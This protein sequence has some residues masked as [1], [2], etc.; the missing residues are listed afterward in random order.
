M[1]EILHPIQVFDLAESEFGAIFGIYFKETPLIR[2]YVHFCP[3]FYRF[4]PKKFYPMGF[5][6][7]KSSKFYCK[8]TF[9]GIIT[10]TRIFLILTNSYIFNPTAV[11]NVFEY[12]K[13]NHAKSQI[14]F[15]T[16]TIFATVILFSSIAILYQVIIW[17]AYKEARRSIARSA[18]SRKSIYE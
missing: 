10:I 9:Q 4:K 12:I 15:K 18:K 17:L 7:V 1:G 14:L 16:A 8:Q 6:I 13:S 3:I 2:L 5:L 11:R